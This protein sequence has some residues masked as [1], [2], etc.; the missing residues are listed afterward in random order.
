VSV[1]TSEDEDLRLTGTPTSCTL[2]VT[3]AS[4]A[5]HHGDWMCLLNDI[6]DFE[7]V[8]GR[9]RLEVAT[10][11]RLSWRLQTGGAGMT[12]TAAT[13]EEDSG[14]EPLVLSVME[15]ERTNVSCVARG[16]FP[17]PRFAWELSSQA[18][19]SDALIL[20][21]GSETSAMA[22]DSWSLLEYRAQLNDSGSNIS[23]RA[24]QYTPDGQQLLY[25]S[26]LLLV[27]DVTP[28]VLPLGGRA[29]SEQ[30]IGILSAILLAIILVILLFTLLMVVMIRRD[31]RRRKAKQKQYADDIEKEGEE[32]ESSTPIWR[33]AGGKS[34]HCREQHHLHH[35]NREQHFQFQEVQH[36]AGEQGKVGQMPA[37]IDR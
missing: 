36:Q 29:V 2:H 26:S 5:H 31:R 27:L 9:V 16:A 22:A 24:E 17:P 10:P 33:P 23:C 3:H 30:M 19:G 12:V 13:A 4:A 20:T 28:L 14:N 37:R 35:H 32:A 25:S 18:N 6:R 11:A 1:C 34:H 7:T 8:R 21:G 15:G